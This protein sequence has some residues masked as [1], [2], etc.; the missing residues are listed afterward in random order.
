MIGP[1]DTPFAFRMALEERLRNISRQQD[2][3]LPRLQ[4]RVALERLLARLF[5]EAEPPRLL[6]GGYAL[7]VHLAYQARSTRDLDLS[8]PEPGRLHLPSEAGISQ[9]RADKL[10]EC[11][12][13]AA[14]RDLGNAFRFLIRAPRSELTGA[15]GGGVRCGVEARLAGRIFA[16]FHVDVGLGNLMLGEPAWV[17]GAPLL[18]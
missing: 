9:E 4:R 17:E 12:Q 14:E 7:E 18:N 5:A 11:P 6:K 16:Q 10:H 3:D 8:V 2:V 13:V 1:Y 15:P